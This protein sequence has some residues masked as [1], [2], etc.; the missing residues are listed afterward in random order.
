MN[1]FSDKLKWG[2]EFLADMLIDSK[3]GQKELDNERGTIA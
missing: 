2:T 3:Y 1:M